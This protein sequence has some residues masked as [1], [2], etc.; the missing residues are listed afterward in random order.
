M[1]AGELTQMLHSLHGL[2]SCLLS[3]MRKK[4]LA[5]PAAGQGLKETEL[6]TIKIALEQH[7]WNITETAQALGIARNTLH[8]KIKS[9]NLR[10]L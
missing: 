7:R 10:N 1:N 5:L 8:R 3:V 9:F 4:G 2:E 6:E